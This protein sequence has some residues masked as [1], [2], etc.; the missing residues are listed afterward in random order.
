MNRR[1]RLPIEPLPTIA[2]AAQQARLDIFCIMHS[3]SA[4]S[5]L[6]GSLPAALLLAEALCLGTLSGSVSDTT[7]TQME[8]PHSKW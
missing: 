5:Q 4:L 2:S 7:R 8:C 1:G 6:C 3:I